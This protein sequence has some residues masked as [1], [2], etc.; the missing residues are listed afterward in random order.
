MLL[1]S[2][3]G[4][5]SDLEREGWEASEGLHNY[6]ELDHIGGGSLCSGGSYGRPG[7]PGLRCPA[8]EALCRQGGQGRLRGGFGYGA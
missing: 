4:S 3:A 6:G 2:K 7:K 1:L 8:G 5:C